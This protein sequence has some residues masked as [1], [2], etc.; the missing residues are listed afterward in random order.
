MD[1][2]SLVFDQIKPEFRVCLAEFRQHLW[3]QE[4][5]NRGN[6][7]ESKL[8]GKRLVFA[9][10]RLDEVMKIPEHEPRERGDLLPDL[11][12]GYLAIRPIDELGAESTFEFTD[13][14]GK[15]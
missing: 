9:C 5:R 15:R 1:A 2:V 13:S 10:G 12:N 3:Q 14:A 7:A 8:A 4:R 6:D 11:G